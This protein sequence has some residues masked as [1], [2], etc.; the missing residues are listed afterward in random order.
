M[1]T[2]VTFLRDTKMPVVEINK[3]SLGQ[4]RTV[5]ETAASPGD[6]EAVLAPRLFALTAN[7][8]T[9]AAFGDMMQYWNFFPASDGAWGRVPVWGFADVIASNASG[10]EV[11]ARV[12]GY[13]PMADQLLIQPKVGKTG[14]ADLSAH[15]QPMAPIYNA[16]SLVPARSEDA[17]ARAAVLQPL[18]TTGFLLDDW[19]GGE[20]FFGADRVILSSASSKTALATA[21]A[22]RHRGTA[23][24]LGLTSARSKSFVEQTGYYD[25]VVT[26]DEIENLPLSSATYID[27]AGDAKVTRAVH[28][29]FADGLKKSVMVGATHFT[30]M[31]PPEPMP[32]P[33]PEM[34]FAPTHSG[35]LGAAWGAAAFADMVAKGLD[36]FAAD[37]ARWMSIST[38]HGLAG[39]E[40]AWA[41]LASGKVPPSEGVVVKL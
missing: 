32:G 26:Y 20:D 8:M 30:G 39:A 4:S 10:V 25:D 13:L 36:A 21:E 14:F 19:I 33:T 37:S 31:S 12:Y 17:E 34:F 29:R 28:M 18:Y 5:N 41:R 27:Y 22:M 16:Y 1:S 6:G 40:A 9:Y 2:C 35:R 24:L 11:G 3:S 15:R 7:N 23:R 38:V